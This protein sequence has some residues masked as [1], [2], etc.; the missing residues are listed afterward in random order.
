MK[1]SDWINEEDWVSGDGG[2]IVVIQSSVIKKWKGAEDFE[3]SLMNG[4]DVETDYDVICECKDGV[5][6]I[7]RYKREMFVLSDCE[8][9]ASLQ[10]TPDGNIVIIQFFGSDKT[11]EEL[12]LECFHIPASVSFPFK[13]KDD[14]LRLLVGADS[15]NGEIWGFSDIYLKPG[16]KHCDVYYSD[17]AQI[18][19][20]KDI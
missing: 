14:F 13:M 4:G 1:S 7:K 5:N 20:I 12:I 3:N 16:L 11:T 2:P 9:S 19:I 15:G 8:W 10:K 6:L 17:E 18:V